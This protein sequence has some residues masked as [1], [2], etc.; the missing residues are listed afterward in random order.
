MTVRYAT[1]L[2]DDR[3][4][5]GERIETLPYREALGGSLKPGDHVHLMAGKYWPPQQR[6]S[7]TTLEVTPKPIVLKGLK[8]TE[9]APTR[10]CGAGRSSIM[11]GSN[12]AV[13]IYPDMPTKDHFAFFKLIDCEWLEIDGMAF[14]SCWPAAIYLENCRYITIRNIAAIDGVYVVFARGMGTK[15]ILVE[16]VDWRQDPSGQTW[17]VLD[18]QQV[19]DGR[20]SYLNGAL[21]GSDAVK[22]NVVVRH[23]R[24]RDAFNAIR[25][26][27]PRGTDMRCANI[28]VEIYDNDFERI[29]D[30]A[31]EPER[32]AL[33]WW[34][35]HNRIANCHSWFSFDNTAGGWRYF[36][37]N[38]G[39]FTSKPGQAF[40]PNTGGKVFKFR[41]KKSLESPDQP[42]FAMHNSWYLRSFLAKKS[43]VKGFKHLNN[44]V[45][46]CQSDD[47]CGDACSERPSL[48]G[49]DF[50][51]L[52]WKR[53]VTFNGD[54]CNVSFG[55]VLGENGQEEQGQVDPAF[56]FKLP[57]GGNMT[58]ADGAPRGVDIALKAGKDWPGAEDWASGDGDKN[59]QVGAVQKDGSLFQGPAFVA[60]ALGKEDRAW[61]SRVVRTVDEI[62]IS[63]TL[64]LKRFAGTIKLIA[65]G[66]RATTKVG[67]QTKGRDLYIF[68]PPEGRRVLDLRDVTIVLPKALSSGNGQPVTTWASPCTNIVSAAQRKVMKKAK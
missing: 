30:N 68:A 22:G 8:A 19:H 33:N 1:Y 4:I 35:R 54:L 65:P 53:S 25:L 41:K 28:N 48:V 13:P 64:P 26:A 51:N 27:A 42:F 49:D 66:E 6:R 43:N 62:K 32:H 50:M 40:D 11:C 37:G 10:I 39:W 38:T 52:G 7:E 61:I 67:A 12:A 16:N 23:C 63:F 34:V 58:P 14:E 57:T 45:Q 47:H 31:V 18:W 15:N 60:L 55:A 17:P 46:F 24:V 44:A 5:N 2:D 21:L 36:F 3:T 20:Y 56:R 59:R 9:A 29:R